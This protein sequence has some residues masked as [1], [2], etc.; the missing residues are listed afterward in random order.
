MD[1]AD[2][3]MPTPRS[4]C[5][6][7][8]HDDSH[9]GVAD[10]KQHRPNEIDQQPC[11]DRPGPQAPTRQFFRLEPSV[12]GVGRIA[13]DHHRACNEI[14]QTLILRGEIHREKYWNT[15]DCLDERPNDGPVQWHAAKIACH[16][17]AQ[18]QA[19][20]TDRASSHVTS[21]GSSKQNVRMAAITNT[22]VTPSIGMRI[23]DIRNAATMPMYASMS[24]MNA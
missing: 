5:I 11:P 8:F 9:N 13:W 24:R 15:K 21:T 20:V 18:V 2:T 3:T 4:R 12:S 10:S 14:V 23:A 19:T 22:G 7:R 17:D 1:S 16:H 6:G